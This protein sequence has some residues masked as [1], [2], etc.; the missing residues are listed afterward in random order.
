LAGTKR[1][2]A[3]HHRDTESAEEPLA[4]TKRQKAIHHRGTESTEKSYASHGW[5]SVAGQVDMYKIF[6]R[7]SKSYN[8]QR[9]PTGPVACKYRA[10]AG[11]QEAGSRKQGVLTAASQGALTK[12]RARTRSVKR[13]STVSS[14]NPKRCEGSG[15]E[16][17]AHER[18]CPDWKHR[19]M[20]GASGPDLN[21]VRVHRFATPQFANLF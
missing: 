11:T 12:D 14:A 9:N 1:Q 15:R 4:G 19:P 21:E 3:I 8:G 17:G 7:F 10:N 6:I 16:L 5:R 13:P 20:V 18:S 2:K